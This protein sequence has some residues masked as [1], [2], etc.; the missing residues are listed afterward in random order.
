MVQI[1]VSFDNLPFRVGQYYLKLNASEV[2]IPLTVEIENK[3]LSF[4]TKGD[5]AT[6]Q[7]AIYGLVRDMSGRVEA[8]FE[9]AL[10]LSCRVEDLP[11]TLRARSMYQRMLTLD[12]R[13]RY[14]IELV[15]KDFGSQKT[16]VYRGAVSPP[17]LPEFGLT[18]S[19]VILSNSVRELERVPSEP[20]MFLLGDVKLHP[21]IGK[22]FPNV[23]PL[24]VYLQIYN[25]GVD[26][27]SLSI[28]LT[29]EYRISRDGVKKVEVIEEKGESLRLYGTG[30]VVLL[31][32]FPVYAFEPGNY[33]LELT[34]RDRLSGDTQVRRETFRILP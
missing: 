25:A 19:S 2:L 1:N 20:E 32:S 26:Q 7:A 10:D 34:V 27:S 33:D 18:L 6:A 11:E 4:V 28:D 29:V 24:S 9:E 17:D 13:K 22:Q 14:K 23:R 3:D 30:R 31:R 5:I 16:G 21:S 8:E 12:R 15:V